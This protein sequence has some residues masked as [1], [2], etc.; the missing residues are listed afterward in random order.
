V[1]AVAQKDAQAVAF[2]TT[3]VTAPADVPFTIHFVNSD[4]AGVLHNVEIKDEGGATLYRGDPI[5][6]GGQET[7]YQV[8][9]IPVGT[10]PFICTVH[11]AMTG[12][13]TVQ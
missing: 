13:M 7:D 11:P 1:G 10:Y 5:I 12:T 6:D 4:P 8:P 3:D 2:T 9:P